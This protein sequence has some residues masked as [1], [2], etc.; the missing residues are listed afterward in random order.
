MPLNRAT[1]EEPW[2]PILIEGTTATERA[3]FRRCRRQ[4]FL[5]VVHRLKRAGGDS[6]FWFGEIVHA[7]LEAYY[8]GIQAKQPW[9][10]CQEAGLSAFADGWKR[11]VAVAREELGGLFDTYAQEYNDAW[12][13]GGQMLPAYFKRDRKT[14]LGKV[15]LVELRHTVPILG[16]DGKPLRRGTISCRYD[17]VVE[18]PNGDIW[19][20][21]HKT[22]SQKPSSAQLDLDD[23]LTA[24][25]YVWWRKTGKW[26]RGQI[27]NV[28]I[29]KIA[30]QPKLLKSGKLSID[31]S[32]STTYSLY[33]EAI[34]EHGL[35]INEYSEVLAYFQAT[36][37]GDFFV[38]EGVFRTR[39]QIDE[40]ERNLYYEF[41]DMNMV[42]SEPE[43]AYPN[44]SPFNCPSCGVRQICQAMMDGREQDPAALIRANY[45]IGEP[46]I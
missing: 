28:L 46:R 27:Y 43:R 8:K 18:K 9:A 29:K 20:I 33:M 21:D 36:G 34:K 26:P 7:G 10:E 41:L 39:G 11:I 23:Q 25:A 3:S 38:S 4:W 5:S 30:T 14:G 40:F 6:N 24:L 1:G 2:S 19:I 45:W 22:A 31:R 42:A 37:D 35:A 12:E 17:L 32:Q 15:I 16:P 13:L 44:P